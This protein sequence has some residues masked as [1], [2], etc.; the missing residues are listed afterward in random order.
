MS[1]FAAALDDRVGIRNLVLSDTHTGAFARILPD[2]GATLWALA[3]APAPENGDTVRD[4]SNA[5]GNSEVTTVLAS[6]TVEEVSE[7]PW[8]RG[9]VLFPF[10]DRIPGGRYRFRGTDF[11]L[12]CNDPGGDDAIH[13][14]VYDRPFE[15]TRLTNTESS[16]IATLGVTLPG[17]ESEGYPFRVRMG[18]T[19][20]LSAAGLGTEF[21][22]RNIGNEP[23]P[24]AM[25]IHPYVCVEPSIDDAWLRC[26]AAR[27][28]EVDNRLIPTGRQPPTAGSELDFS[29]FRRL[30]RQELDVAFVRSESDSVR[31][32]AVT[33]IRR[34][35]DII[36]VSQ[37]IPPFKYTQ[38]FTAPDRRSIAVEPVTAATDSFN[39]P[40]LGLRVLAPGDSFAG[41]VILAG[42]TLIR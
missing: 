6:D 21:L 34:S 9:R 17:A 39:R 4:T 12:R 31:N 8:F 1:R 2:H 38:L 24:V 42:R 10:N 37:S 32:Y 3:L 11:Q 25:G 13:G 23:A 29:R 7:N 27:T 22:C 15:I 36:S 26:P 19:Y 20:E 35:S 18:L 28:V 41:H 33:E 5:A 30:Q 16:A 14:L 40:E